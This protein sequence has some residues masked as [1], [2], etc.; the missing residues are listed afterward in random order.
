LR[1]GRS[2]LLKDISQVIDNYTGRPR[3]VLEYGL[4]A[5]RLVDEAKKPGFSVDSWAPLAEL[6]ATDEFERV[7]AFKEVMD[8][9]AYIDFMTNWATSSEWECSLRGVTETPD[10]VFLELEERS[11]IGEFANVVN[12][13][14]V[15]EFDDAGKIRHI[16]LYL[17]ME[18]PPAEMLKS[19][20]GVQISE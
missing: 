8:W 1:K 5:K 16:D 20:E 6:V 7:G 12:S 9:P 15:Y 14:S 13:L 11:R 4:V 2:Q 3:T 17:Q 18:L 10:R 19:F